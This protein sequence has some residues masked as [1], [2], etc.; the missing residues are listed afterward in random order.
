[1]SRHMTTSHQRPIT[2]HAQ[3]MREGNAVKQYKE[4]VVWQ[5]A[6]DLGNKKFGV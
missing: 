3:V 1:M 2:S 6:M 5:K 4:L